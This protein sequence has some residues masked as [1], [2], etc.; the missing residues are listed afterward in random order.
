MI[1]ERGNI[2]MD[3]P[4]S[5]SIPRRGHTSEQTTIHR[6]PPKSPDKLAH[7][8]NHPT[9]ILSF[10]LNLETNPLLFP[11]CEYHT[12]YES[13]S[14][15]SMQDPKHYATYFRSTGRG[16]GSARFTQKDIK[17]KTFENE[18][19]NQLKED[20]TRANR[21]NYHG[22]TGTF[23]SPSKC[24]KYQDALQNAEALL[25]ENPLGNKVNTK[26]V[27]NDAVLLLHDDILEYK[28]WCCAFVTQQFSASFPPLKDEITVSH[29]NDYPCIMVS[30]QHIQKLDYKEAWNQLFIAY[31]I[32]IT[33]KIAEEKCVP[34]EL[35]HRSGFGYHLPTIDVTGECFRI[36]IGLVPRIYLEILVQ[37]L[38]ELPSIMDIALKKNIYAY[39]IKK[40]RCVDIM[41]NKIKNYKVKLPTWQKEHSLT[42]ILKLE[43]DA[44]RQPIIIQM[45][46]QRY[47]VDLLAQ[48]VSTELDKT[49]PNYAM[50]I[51][52]MLMLLDFGKTKKSDNVVSMKVNDCM[53]N[54]ASRRWSHNEHPAIKTDDPFWGMVERIFRSVNAHDADSQDK[55]LLG[56]NARLEKANKEVIIQAVNDNEI[57]AEDG[58]GSDSE[59]EGEY[60]DQ[61]LFAKKLIVHTGMRA[62]NVAYY[63]ARYFLKKYQGISEYQTHNSYMYYETD[64]IF[65]AAIDNST[66]A[67][68]NQR[69]KNIH[70]L[71]FFDLNHCDT[72]AETQISLE[73]YFSQQDP[74]KISSAI[75]LDCTSATADKVSKSVASA[76]NYGMK[77]ILLVSSG[78][79]H[80]QNS[81]DNHPY[82]TVRII[83]IDKNRLS[84]LYNKAKNALGGEGMPSIFHKMRKD[85]KARGHTLTNKKILPQVKMDAAIHGR[86]E[87]NRYKKVLLARLEELSD[88]RKKGGIIVKNIE[89]DIMKKISTIK[90]QTTNTRSKVQ[91]ITPSKADIAAAFNKKETKEAIFDAFNRCYLRLSPEKM[92]SI[93]NNCTL[94][95]DE[96]NTKKPGFLTISLMAALIEQFNTI[97]NTFNDTLTAA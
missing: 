7:K 33:N 45:M 55:V 30:I 93:L 73:Q 1:Y 61:T 75:I 42:D 60:S 18:K 8:A 63:L 70:V 36:N 16:G 77:L 40:E 47:Y 58:I 92:K 83:T 86:D 14:H 21:A 62:I 88:R 3:N 90:K 84:R 51:I 5:A 81:A 39:S 80:E 97:E 50:P 22:R 23:H 66:F 87:M 54:H 56:L 79:K 32:A 2:S 48:K 76:I 52:N 29:H 69:K 91:H 59:C 96:V 72:T 49:Q 71:P 12:Q 31:F 4:V 57:E 46:R 13:T 74:N 65:N 37:S 6:D 28:N 24:K 64:S 26:S 34:I 10:P 19:I 25:E 44:Q 95:F 43:G 67:K 53:F 9:R 15:F 17:S 89:T 78:L 27:S 11:R 41:N 82:G 35:A 94:K 85:Y 38:G 68:R 20:L